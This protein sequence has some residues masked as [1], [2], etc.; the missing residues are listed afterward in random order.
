LGICQVVEAGTPKISGMIAGYGAL[1]TWEWLKSWSGG[2][3]VYAQR[4]AMLR[5]ERA[6]GE[7]DAAGMRF[8]IPSDEEWPQQLASL[9]DAELDGRGGVPAGL[10]L[11]GPGNLNDMCTRAVTIVGSRASTRYGEIVATELAGDLARQDPPVTVISGGAY[12][13]DASAH[14]G[15]LAGEGVSVGVFAQGLDNAYPRG[16]ASLFERLATEQLVVSEMPLGFPPSKASFL[17][18]NRLLAA[19]SQGTI[20]VEAAQ[21]SGA[22]NT[23]SWAQLLG[24]ELMATPGPVTSATSVTPNRL[25]R[26]GQAHL[27]T[28]TEDAMTV[29][30]DTTRFNID[31]PVTVED[32]SPTLLA[33][34]D[35]FPGHGSRS[36]GELS[37]IS[38]VHVTECLASLTEL[39]DLRLV[40]STS[41]GWRRG[42]ASQGQLRTT[43]QVAVN[44][45]NATRSLDNMDRNGARQHATPVAP[46]SRVQTPTLPPTPALR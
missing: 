40:S 2:Y 4:A 41:S 10:W 29:L 30:G 32:L 13:I 31:V 36:A 35:A 27:I 28:S 46:S 33:V 22:R 43:D 11:K 37:L 16:N 34:L 14:R 6:A 19:L 21:R 24:R 9:A 17:A 25:I 26:D 7:T 42:I 23:A 5:L 15:A 8:I 39:E 1:E 44:L 12:G 18:R 3:E 45:K 20:I 38:G